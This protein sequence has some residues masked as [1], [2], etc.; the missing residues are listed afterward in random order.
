LR[1]SRTLTMRRSNPDRVTFIRQSSNDVTTINFGEEHTVTVKMQLEKLRRL[2]STQESLELL[3]SHCGSPILMSR[4]PHL[5]LEWHGQVQPG[6]LQSPCLVSYVAFFAKGRNYRRPDAE[7]VPRKGTL[8]WFWRC[9]RIVAH[10]CH[11]ITIATQDQS[12]CSILLTKTPSSLMP[13]RCR[14]R[15]SGSFQN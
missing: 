3:P 12:G 10:Y 1:D 4:H 15:P 13:N 6:R 14:V 11:A 2:C 7:R 5:G 9:F 8:G